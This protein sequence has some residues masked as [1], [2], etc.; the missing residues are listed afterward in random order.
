MDLRWKAGK[1]FCGL[2]QTLN[3]NSESVRNSNR[4]STSN[5]MKKFSV[6]FCA[7]G[8]L[9]WS[10]PSPLEYLKISHTLSQT[11]IRHNNRKTRSDCVTSHTLNENEC[12]FS[13][14][15]LVQQD[16]CND[17]GGDVA[18]CWDGY[19]NYLNS[20]RSLWRC[21]LVLPTVQNHNVHTLDN[22]YS[23]NIRR[24]RT[25]PNR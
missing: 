5:K 18:T 23:G 19:R 7:G 10:T 9:L 15:T 12:R 4:S 16:T 6:F 25:D 3:K 13:Q 8:V 17:A 22:H 2:A 20:G 14:K 11:C 21:H 24:R 1:S